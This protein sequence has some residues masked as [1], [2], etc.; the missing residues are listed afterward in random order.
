MS[1]PGKFYLAVGCIC[2]CFCPTPAQAHLVN[3]KVGPFYAGM[4]HPLTSLEHLLPMLALALFAS[5]YGKGV[6]R[7][8]LLVF[9]MALLAGLLAGNLLPAYN[10]VHLANLMALVGLGALLTLGNCTAR[11]KPSVI[12]VIVSVVGLIL[13]YRSGNDMAVS[14]VPAQFVPGVVLTD[15][16]SLPSWARGCR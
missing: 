16:F 15:S 10:V 6:V 12:E 3:T 14:T 11:L 2:V 9:P 8:T 7:W 5:S 13:G 4:M 1:R